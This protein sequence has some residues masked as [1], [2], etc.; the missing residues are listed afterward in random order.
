MWGS[1]RSNVWVVGG[2]LINSAACCIG[3]MSHYDGKAWSPVLVPTQP[4][5]YDVWGIS[6]TDVWVVGDSGTILHGA[7]AG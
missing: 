4:M 5:L 2:N 7:P 1:S 3:A 6:A